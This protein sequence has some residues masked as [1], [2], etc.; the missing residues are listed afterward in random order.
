MA[1]PARA[2]GRAT[3]VRFCYDDRAFAT[4][5]NGL[6]AVMGGITKIASKFVGLVVAGVVFMAV[7]ETSA[8]MARISGL[9]V[10]PDV[11]NAKGSDE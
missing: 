6:F 5:T 2:T 10:V 1:N 9:V 3:R 4:W 8:P 7:P 11:E